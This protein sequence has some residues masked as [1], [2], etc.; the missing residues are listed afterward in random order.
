MSNNRSEENKRFARGYLDEVWNR[1]QLDRLEHWVAADYRG[2]TRAAGQTPAEGTE[3]LRRWVAGLFATF[4]DVRKEVKALLA[5][6][7]DVVA[8]VAFTGTHAATGK[9]IRADQLY[10]LRLR[11]GKIASESI[12]FDTGGVLKELS[13][14]PACAV[15]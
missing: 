9:T 14:P 3:G 15:R 8:E 4:S 7:D 6:G 2:M 1:G 11:D 13:A 10:L 12:F 5:D